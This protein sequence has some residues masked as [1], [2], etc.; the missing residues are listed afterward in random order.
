MLQL[1]RTALFNG[2]PNR[3]RLVCSSAIHRATLARRYGTSNFSAGSDSATH[4]MT[5]F[6]GIVAFGAVTIWAS[7]THSERAENR[8]KREKSMEKRWREW[9]L[10]LRGPYFHD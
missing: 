3:A 1:A 10:M 2:A 6:E 5:L 8:A 7:N 4:L 9:A